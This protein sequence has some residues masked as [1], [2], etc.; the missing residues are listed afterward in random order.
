MRNLTSKQTYQQ[1]RIEV[2]EVQNEASVM[3]GSNTLP[4]VGDGGGI[5]Q[6]SSSGATHTGTKHQ[7]ASSLQEMEDMLNDLLTF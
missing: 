3:T 6:S 4:D 5:F 1:P 7:Q 2:I